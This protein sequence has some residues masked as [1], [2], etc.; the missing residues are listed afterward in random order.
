MAVGYTPATLLITKVIPAAERPNLLM[1]VFLD[2]LP[3][4]GAADRLAAFD[5]PERLHLEG[6]HL[7]IDYAE[8]VGRSKLTPALLDKALKVPATGRNWNTANTLL[9]MARALEG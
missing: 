6:E 3:Q 7:Y 9:G 2:G 4:A 5:G 1:V 8:G